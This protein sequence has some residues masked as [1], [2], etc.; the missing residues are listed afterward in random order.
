MKNERLDGGCRGAEG[1]ENMKGIFFWCDG[2]ASFN[3]SARA[4]RLS[5]GVHNYELR[6]IV[7]WIRDRSFIG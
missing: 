1:V 5:L 7:K 2:R 6:Y 4:L 3:A